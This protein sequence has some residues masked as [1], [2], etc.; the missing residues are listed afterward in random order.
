ML[1]VIVFVP[2]NIYAKFSY[3]KDYLAIVETTLKYE[4]GYFKEENTNFGI[5]QGTYDAF[6]ISKGLQ[7]QDVLCI[8]KEEVYECYYVRYYKRGGCDTL[9]PLMAMVHFDTC[10]NFG[11]TG[12]S[13][14]LKR[15]L[16]N[17][18]TTTD[19]ELA[20]KYCETRILKRYEIVEVKPSKR[21]FLKGWVNRDNKL[22]KM[23]LDK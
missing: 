7:T 14:L 4:G 5:L 2:T 6:R 3:D 20:I 23:I 15:T 13:I 16:K 18:N 22:K 17:T 21:R 11:I 8:T 12:A 9:S 10:V 1:L 19:K